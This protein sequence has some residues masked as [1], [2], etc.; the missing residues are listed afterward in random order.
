VVVQDGQV[1]ASREVQKGDARA[2]G[3]LAAG[4]HG[5]V[6]GRIFEP[7][8]RPVLTF[9]PTRQHTHSS[10]VRLSCLDTVQGVRHGAHGLERFDVPIVD[11]TGGLRPEAIPGVTVFKI[12]Q[13]R[14][15]DSRGDPRDEVELN[16]WLQHA[17]G[18]EPLAGL[19]AEGMAPYGITD[20][21]MDRALRRVVRCGVPVVRVGRGNADGFTH[22]DGLLL[23]GNNLTAT[24]ARLLLMAG[25]LR[26]GMLPPA[27]DPD[28]PSAAEEA[29]LG[30]AL[31]AYQDLFDTH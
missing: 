18:A 30:S 24:K 31:D 12:G 3:Y 15:A 17:L 6:V 23:G 28:T 25:L 19:V 7:P 21:R 14:Q 22:R 13:Y 10:A 5:G 27:R 29:A 26:Y 2:G 1:F 4:G 9:V 11:A 20:N 8:H 16:A